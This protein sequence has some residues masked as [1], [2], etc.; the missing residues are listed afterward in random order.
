MSGTFGSEVRVHPIEKLPFESQF[1]AER[2][3]TNSL[4]AG[5]TRGGMAALAEYRTLMVV[6]VSSLVN[7]SSLRAMGRVFGPVITIAVAMVWQG[8][9]TFADM[10]ELDDKEE[11]GSDRFLTWLAFA[12]VGLNPSATFTNTCRSS[13]SVTLA[14]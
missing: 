2:Q 4:Q 14:W 9:Y 13:W 8:S 1:T 6:A 7:T 3:V 11:R 5:T 10:A 12:W